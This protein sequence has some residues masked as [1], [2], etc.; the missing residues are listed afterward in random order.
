LISFTKNIQIWDAYFMN[1][2]LLITLGL[3]KR[4]P[5]LFLIIAVL[6]PKSTSPLAQLV[7]VYVEDPQL[8]PPF[9]TCSDSYWYPFTNNRGH[10]AYLTLNALNPNNSTNHGEWHPVITQSG[11][12]RV[13]AYIPAHSPIVW[14]TGQRR[15]IDHDTTDAHYSIHH[16]YGIT[17]RSFSQYPLSNQWL[18]LGE[19]Y[20]NIG[21]NGYVSL[22]DLNGEVEFSTTISFSAMR[23][24]LTRITRP[25]TY[26]PIVSF[27]EPPPPPDPGTGVIQAQGFDACH[28]P[29]ISE[30]QTWWKQSPYDFYALYMGGISL[31][32]GCTVA[33]STWVNTVH[34]QG[35]SF[36]P[37]WVGPQAPCSSYLHKMSSDP[38]VTYQQGRAE[39]E[40]ASAKAVSM[41]LAKDGLGGTVIYY[42]LEVFGG[43]NE[44]CRK[45]TS[46]FMNGWVERLNELGNI[47]GGYGAHNS[48]IEDWVTIPH[49][50]S[51]VWIASWYTN[52]YDPAASVNGIT[53]LNGL[54]TSRQRIRQYTGGHN[55]TWGST[56]FNIDSD[57]AD[58]MVA[59]PPVK[60]LINPIVTATLSIEDIGWLS[61]DQGWLV[62]GE[63]LYLTNDQGKHWQEL[64]PESIQMAYFLPS[65]L[66]WAISS[67]DEDQLS[68][69]T[70]SSRGAT[71]ESHDLL[72]PPDSN[73]HPLQLM[74]TSPASGWM[75]LQKETSQAF[76]SGMLMKTSD[77][78]LTWQS[79]DLPAAA[80][81]NFVSESEGWMINRNGDELFHTMDGGETW[82]LFPISQ[83]ALSQLSLP[84]GTT[85]SGHQANGLGWAAISTNHCTGVR[86]T[87][88]FN[89]Q[90][91]TGLQQT[92]D[93]GK[94]WHEIPLPTRIPIKR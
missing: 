9:S 72:L 45:A 26:L 34:K 74:F 7:E 23:F 92:L 25:D 82:Q 56:K 29:E 86:S 32:S 22:T 44:A 65:G 53:W 61:A 59:L 38:A 5:L 2:Q 81:I 35:W 19:F 50:P 73:W 31:Y 77:A 46:A 88:S 47:A 80:P 79:Y 76:D 37:T 70:S 87:S 42:D 93:G 58:G 6:V 66:A 68:L 28:L 14:C 49:I 51:V 8:Q 52:D 15:T 62:V 90:I 89:C 1:I 24:T 83:Y 54:W 94:T 64:S 41:G 36:L 20:F 71:W 60:P 30:M 16:A 55:E 78:G 85:F 84:E 18:D 10:N 33:N 69:L 67:Q 39:A 13:E 48:Y 75:V 3:I 11:Y 40:A 91:A 57:I 63:R 4:L 12:Y 21:S 43:A 17:S 27:A